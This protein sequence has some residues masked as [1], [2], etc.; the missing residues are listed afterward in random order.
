MS[1]VADNEATKLPGASAEAIRHHYDAGNEFYALW[2]DESTCSYTAA[3]YEDEAE[4]LERAQERKLDHHLIAAGAPNASRILDIGSGWGNLLSRAVNVHGVSHATG[5]T[6]S[7]EQAAYLAKVA[8]P[9]LDVRVEHWFDHTPDAPYDAIF[10]IESIEAFVKPGL[11]RAEKVRTYRD[12]FDRC[13]RWLRP[14]GRL[15]LQFI[16]YGNAFPEDLDS[17]ISAEI[18]PESDLPYLSEIA[19]ASERLFEIVTLRN[20]RAD[21]ATTLRAWLARLKARRAEA[22]ALVGEEV[23]ARYEQYLRL[24]IY[25]F[26]S[27]GCDLHRVAF[28]RIDRPRLTKEP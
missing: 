11:P 25:M 5:L 14:G 27:G 26:A 19:E 22:V 15:S 18:F 17:F 21:Y 4:P 24:C 16:A 23:V 20:D 8:D 28:R 1:E 2:L 6:L 12:L 7:R 13:H 9:R 3:L 10:S